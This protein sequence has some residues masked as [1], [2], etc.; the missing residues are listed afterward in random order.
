[1]KAH[2][3]GH[4]VDRQPLLTKFAKL[5]KSIIGPHRAVSTLHARLQAIELSNNR[6]SSNAGSF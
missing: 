3:V 2:P 6:V 5:A 1:M 4:L